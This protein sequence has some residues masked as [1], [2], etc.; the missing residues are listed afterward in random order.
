MKKIPVLL[1]LL[2]VV[3]LIPATAQDDMDMS[4]GD[5]AV[6]EWT[7]VAVETGVCLYDTDYSFFVRPAE[8]ETS[9]LM[10]YFQGGG[11]CWDTMTCSAVGQFASQYDVTADEMDF[12]QSGFFDYANEANPVADY[13][14]VFVPY[15]S[16]DI[17]GGD[18][19]ATYDIPDEDDDLTVQFRG[20]DNAFAVLDWVFANFTAPEQVFVTG[21]SAGGYGAA[22]H[23]PFIMQNYADVPAVLLSDSS[24][25]VLVP[26]WDGRETWNI[27]ASN[28]EFI[29][30]LDALGNDTETTLTFV[31]TAKAFPDNTFAQYNTFLDNVQVGFYGLLGGTFVTEENFAEVATGWSTGLLTNL[32]TIAAS[33]DNFRSYTAG[34]LQHCIVNQPEFYDTTVEDVSLSDWVAGLLSADVPASISCD[35]AGGGC[36]T[37]PVEE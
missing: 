24:N 26:E 17:H 28:P 29:E 37:S 18:A 25:G 3:M 13:N 33:A 6:G 31:E 2:F 32:G 15:C 11:A 12:Y 22:T 20:V 9:K 14:A 30:S 5:M 21:C 19:E 35:V 16:G 27:S 8:T 4:F 23:A 7:Q 36:F 34:G 1:M 10:V